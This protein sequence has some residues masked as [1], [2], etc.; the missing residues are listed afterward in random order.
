MRSA[1]RIR[2]PAVGLRIDPYV[3]VHRQPTFAVRQTTHDIWHSWF[4]YENGIEC[5][6][7]DTLLVRIDGRWRYQ[8]RHRRN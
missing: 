1:A 3:P 2:K 7:C 8:G 6:H 5:S 4:L